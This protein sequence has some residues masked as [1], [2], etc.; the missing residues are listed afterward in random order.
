MIYNRINSYY[1]VLDIDGYSNVPRFITSPAI[2][3][4][5]FPPV[6]ASRSYHKLL[7]V[8]FWSFFSRKIKVLY[9]LRI[10]LRRIEFR[11]KINNY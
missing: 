2:D 7:M 4:V 1:T 5:S 10:Y 11:D 9:L 3:H 6:I 8:I